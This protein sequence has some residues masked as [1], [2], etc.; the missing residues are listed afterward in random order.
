M[1]SGAASS[2]RPAD[3]TLSS[4][5][6]LSRSA[7]AA[8]R[9]RAVIPARTNEDRHSRRHVGRTR[10]WIGETDTES[11]S[12]RPSLKTT[13]GRGDGFSPAVPGGARGRCCEAS[14]PWCGRRRLRRL[15]LSD[16]AGLA[17]HYPSPPWDLESTLGEGAGEEPET[18][19]SCHTPPDRFLSS[20]LSCPGALSPA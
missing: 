10:T 15:H 9:I 20:P 12:T 5:P 17:G 11:S 14:W 18:V 13:T 19:T 2:P 16:H 4:W 8:H 7:T 6:C 3:S 1:S